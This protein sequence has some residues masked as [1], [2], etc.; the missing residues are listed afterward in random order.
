[1]SVYLGIRA[2][3][4]RS[5]RWQDVDLNAGTVLIRSSRSRGE[6]AG[7]KSGHE[8]TLPIP[9]PLRPFLSPPGPAGALVCRPARGPSTPRGHEWSDN[10]LLNAL[11]RAARRLGIAGAKFHGFR[12]F[13]ATSRLAAG[14]DVETVRVLLGHKDLGTTQRYVHTTDERKRA[15]VA[16]GWDELTGNSGV[17]AANTGNMSRETKRRKAS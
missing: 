12:H 4:V 17:T 1:L 10:G 5:L 3:E 6:T 8:R 7:T 9:D 14:A 11:K 13:Y 2:G 15:A 16:G